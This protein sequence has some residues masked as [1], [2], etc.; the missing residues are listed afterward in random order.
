MIIKSM[1]RKAPTFGQLI[2]YIGR[3]AHGQEPFAHN[4]YHAG[5][6]TGWVEAQFRENYC[7]LFKRKNGNALYHEIL[8][9]EPQPHLSEK[10]IA[11]K[12]QKIAKVYCDT[13]APDHLAWGQTHHDTDFPHV[14]LMISSNAVNSDRRHRLT[15]DQFAQ[16]QRATE[17]YARDHFPELNLTAVYERPTPSKNIKKLRNEGE[18]ERRTS[19]PSRKERVA[20]KVRA[21]LARSSNLNEL[22]KSLREQGFKLHQRGQSWSIEDEQSS[23]RY[24]L[25]TLGF[26]AE[27]EAVRSAQKA[28]VVPPKTADQVDSR[29]AELERLAAARLQEFEQERQEERDR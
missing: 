8:A 3:D 24:R 16:A 29:R 21:C 22:S 9:L 28:K 17:K 26:F 18:L 2:D 11:E 15:K 14:H 27:F 25:K 23:K 13:R 4:L 12:L 5:I 6:N 19:Q 20:A 10:E 1:A 7:N